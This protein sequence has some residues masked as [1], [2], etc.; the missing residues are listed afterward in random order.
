MAKRTTLVIAH[1]IATILSCDRIMVLDQGRIVE[2]GTH[3]RLPR[4]HSLELL[5]RFIGL[6]VSRAVWPHI[7]SSD[8]PAS[9]GV[10]VLRRVSS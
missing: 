5:Y 1:R 6:R 9:T 8:V 3:E 4:A 10:L 2:V 7:P